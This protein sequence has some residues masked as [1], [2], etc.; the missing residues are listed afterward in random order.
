VSDEEKQTVRGLLEEGFEALARLTRFDPYTAGR[1]ITYADFFAY[2]TLPNATW[3]TR[4]AYDW[5]TYRSTR[6]RIRTFR[7]TQERV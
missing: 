7:M 1:E 5:E 2:F 3:M 6:G 4:T